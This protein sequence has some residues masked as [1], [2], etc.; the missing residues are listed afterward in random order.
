M[1]REYMCKKCGCSHFPPTGK[2]CQRLAIE[3][4]EPD[5]DEQAS[6]SGETDMLPL[7]LQIQQQMQSMNDNMNQKMQTMEERMRTMEVAGQDSGA[8]GH[9]GDQ[10]DDEERD[11]DNESREGAM[12][13]AALRND[14]RAMQRA[15]QRIAQFNEDEIDMEDGT[16]AGRTKTPGKK[17]GTLLVAE[18]NVRKRIDWPHMYVQRAVA[19]KR[20]GV[21]YKELRIDEFVYGFLMMLKSPRGN[22]NK[23]VM[24]DI[25]LMLMEDS[26]EFC[27]ENARGF[28][29]LLGI[30]VESGTKKWTDHETIW[31]MR[32][33]QSRTVFGE[34]K[35]AKETKKGANVRP[36]GQNLKCC[37]LY[38][39]RACEQSLDHHPF[40]HA[41]SY[42]AR[43]TGVSYR[44]PEEDCFRK[45]ID[46]SKNS[47][48]RE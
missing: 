29:G 20:S 18:D 48:K 15:A 36:S 19:G 35:E 9:Q 25:L 38:Q 45:A 27:W 42:C 6:S 3:V 14:M 16:L 34:K 32:M 43:T 21:P 8:S 22:W 2:K 33:M 40:T 17:S 11:V 5:M 47:K 26:M 31:K 10:S 23:E 39:K 28:Y 46:E 7:L 4:E 1:P 41:C 12:A 30:D 13:P 24:L 37:A 44:H